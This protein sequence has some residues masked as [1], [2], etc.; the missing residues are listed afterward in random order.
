MNDGGGQAPEAGRIDHWL[1][2]ACLF[3]TRSAAQRAIRAGQVE[4][5]GQ[6]VKP[7]RLLRPGDEIVLTRGS[8]GRQTL[9]VR[10][11][12]QHHLPKAE[13]RRLYEDRTPPPTP[14]ELE[15]R[16]VARLLRQAAPT[17]PSGAPGARDRRLLRRL[18]GKH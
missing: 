5:N 12:A 2:V 7:H 10:A 18:R 16:R 1:D 13:A 17:Q 9:V 3:K 6:P 11:L 14:E 15:A 4:V 8:A